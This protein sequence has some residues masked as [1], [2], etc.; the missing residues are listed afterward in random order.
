MPMSSDAG[1][2]IL[3]DDGAV[4]LDEDGARLLSDGASD[5]DCC[6]HAAPDCCTSNGCCFDLA[7]ARFQFHLYWRRD[8]YASLDGSGAIAHTFIFEADIDLQIYGCAST[9]I[10]SL[11]EEPN[12]LDG[13]PILSNVT[14]TWDGV[15]Q[16][17]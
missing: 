1:T 5:C 10:F 4:T 16:A 9:P 7:N 11:G 13:S 3:Q 2:T 15:D 6:G 17:V 12:N 8:Y 14:C